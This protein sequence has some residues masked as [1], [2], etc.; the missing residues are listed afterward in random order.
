MAK[1]KRSFGAVWRPE[2]STLVEWDPGGVLV[3]RPWPNPAAWRQAT[4]ENARWLHARGSVRTEA[5][6]P[7]PPSRGR[8]HPD[9]AVTARRTAWQTVPQPVQL[10]VERISVQGE[11]W[12]ALALLARCTGAAE[13]AASVPLLAG[14]LTVSGAL[15]AH[16]VSQPLRSAR[17]LLRVPDG[18]ARWRKIAAWLGFD[19]SKSFVNLLRG[20]VR[21]HPW[22]VAEFRKLQQV[23][24]HPL[25]RKRLCHAKAVDLGVVRALHV[26]IEFDA[27]ERLPSVLFD[28]AFSGGGYTTVDINLRATIPAWRVLVPEQPLPQWRTPEEVEAHRETLRVLAVHMRAAGPDPERLTAFP[29]PPIAGLPNIQPLTSPEALLAEGEAMEHCLGWPMWERR[30]RSLIGYAYV[31]T[32]GKERANLWIQRGTAE[33]DRFRV[34]ELRGPKNAPV[35]PE[36]IRFVAG[37]LLPY[38][39]GA[40]L[41]DP[42]SR[43]LVFGIAELAPAV[44]A[45]I[46]DDDIPF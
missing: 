31:A 25:G 36:M 45:L 10:A 29:P 38:D 24:A 32:L 16:P 2:S 26:A 30:A 40:K 23:W 7:E 37:W 33:P 3:T 27:L 1:K 18:M 6:H 34:T 22:E 21:E 35:S 4:A 41:G 9:P 11:E 44:Q 42:W 19:S 20:M 43:P 39:K 8:R 17:A 14:A 13:L 46:G 5:W 28:A 12:N 15:R